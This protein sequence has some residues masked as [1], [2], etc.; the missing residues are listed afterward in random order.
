MPDVRHGIALSMVHDIGPVT[1]RKLF[2]SFGTL[3]I[4][5]RQIRTA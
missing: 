1:S 3:K 4:F 2:A 5:L